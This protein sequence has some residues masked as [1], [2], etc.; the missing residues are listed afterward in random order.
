MTIFQ[1]MLIFLSY[2]ISDFIT[3]KGV[4]LFEYFAVRGAIRQILTEID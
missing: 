4:I 2:F 1:N 3:A